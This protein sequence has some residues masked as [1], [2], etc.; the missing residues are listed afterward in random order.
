VSFFSQVYTYRALQPAAN[1]DRDKRR[2]F[3]GKDEIFDK[4]TF[5]KENICTNQIEALMKIQHNQK[6]N[7]TLGKKT[8]PKPNQTKSLGL[9]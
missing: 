9:L 4:A 7:R 3:K 2:F 5:N 6:G 1:R 8:M